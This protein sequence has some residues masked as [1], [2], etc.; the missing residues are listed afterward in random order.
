MPIYEFGSSGIT[1]LA[2]TTFETAGLQERR[3]LQRLLREYIGVVA[4]DTLVISEEFGEWEDSRRRIDLLAIDKAANLVVIELKRTE[5]GGH[6]ELQAIRYAAMVAN[7]KFDKV[8][9]VYGRYLRLHGREADDPR[10]RILQFLEWDEADDSEFAQDVRIVL[11]SAD[12]SRE[13]TTS[14][15]WL[16]DRGDLGIRCI[17]LTPYLLDGRILVE[18]QP[19]IPL[20]ETAEYQ[21]Q[22]REKAQ[23]E[24]EARATALDFTHFDL[25]IR[26]ARFPDL[27]KRHAILRVFQYLCENG[28]TPEM[29]AAPIPRGRNRVI[30][31]VEGTLNATEFF[32][33][34]SERAASGTNAQSF[35]AR[36][37][38]GGDA[39]LI[40]TNG[41]TYAVSNQWGGE[42]WREAMDRIS[43]AFPQFNIRISE[44]A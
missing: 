1:R 28:I 5:D 15:L 43:I 13:L 44:A 14:V 22:L 33:R 25:S 9:E 21:V 7:M 30:L 36:R 2:E 18:V 40:H 42:K 31:V 20:P 27:T 38:F 35:D 17:R 12:F 10:E 8:V 39:E 26:D 3:D 11:V 16:N 32:A 4:P 23:K 41:K 37:W 6:M 34:A 19:I 29:V 24:R